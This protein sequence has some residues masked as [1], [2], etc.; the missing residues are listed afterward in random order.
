MTTLFAALTGLALLAPRDSS[1]AQ[2]RARLHA[3]ADSS[4]GRL[5]VTIVHV[6]TGARI[7]IG[8]AEPHP[9]MSVFKFP[10]ALTLLHQVERGT[11]SLDSVIHIREND[12]RLG[13]SPL[14]DAHP[15]GDFDRSVGDLLEDMLL[16]SD[17]STADVLL[18][19]VG[20]PRAVTARLHELGITG[21]RIDRSEGQLAIDYHGIRN[22][23]PQSKWT[24]DTLRKLIDAEPAAARL[25][26]ARA[27]ETDRRD[28]ATP[29]AMADLLLLTPRGKALGARETAHLL[30]IMTR[31]MTSPKRLR[32]M[33][34]EGTA[35]AHRGGT[36]DITANVTAAQNDVGIITLPGN[37]GQLAIAVFVTGAHKTTAEV[38]DVIARIA[39]AAYDQWAR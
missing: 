30:D 14:A 38:D 31:T 15:H 1:L 33:L 8:G 35:V 34:P 36:S 9:M 16:R 3:L 5:G 10:L 7:A 37:K 4:G 24:R 39:R 21:V 19:I 22:P 20:G 28:T 2:L 13:V 6:P 11:V 12:L 27:Y 18:R 32:G 17:N 26:A 29:D 25:A 23:P